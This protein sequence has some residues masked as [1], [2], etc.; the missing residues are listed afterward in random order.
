MNVFNSRRKSLSIF[1]KKKKMLWTV[2]V[3]IAF[4]FVS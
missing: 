2:I 4:I 3:K 1:R